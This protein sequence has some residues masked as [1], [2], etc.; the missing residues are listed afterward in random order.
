MHTKQDG[1][2]PW[3]REPVT[4]TVHAIFNTFKNRLTGTLSIFTAMVQPISKPL[5]NP[6]HKQIR[7][8]PIVATLLFSMACGAT[9]STCYGTTSNGSLKDGV[10]LPT[11][12]NN[13]KSYSR[14]A[15]IAGRTFVHSEVRNIVVAAYQSLELTHPEKVYKYAETGKRNGGPFKPHKTHQNGLSADFMTPVKNATGKSVHLPT[16]ALNR[17]G[18][19]IE[20]NQKNEYKGLTIDYIALAAHLVELHKQA[21]IRGHDLWRVIF[22]PEL[23]PPLFDTEYG[24]Y[25]RKNI[26]FSKKRSWVRHNEHY[27]V[28]F[29][30]ACEND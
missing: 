10:R 21:K 28:D 8:L 6:G 14:A 30:I 24:K 1:L 4:L 18:Y 23:Q 19:H 16:H 26:L 17:L 5:R 2:S 22:A 15:I 29:A 25:L 9:E 7:R 12:G 13:Y 11:A 27:H 3:K 20:F